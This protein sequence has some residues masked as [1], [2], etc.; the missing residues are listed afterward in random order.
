MFYF[1]N[2]S[3][4][5]DRIINRQQI[6]KYIDREKD[7]QLD[8]QI[9]VILRSYT[10]KFNLDGKNGFLVYLYITKFASSQ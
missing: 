4:N 9:D 3:K 7:R 2:K 10:A 5:I 1:Q 8:R 6:D